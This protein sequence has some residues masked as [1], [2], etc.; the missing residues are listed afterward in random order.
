[1][2]VAV[3]SWNTRELLRGCLGSLELAASGGLADVWVVDNGSTDG[4]AAMVAAEF[5][6]VSLL[7]SEENSGFGPAV[8]DVAQRSSGEWVAPANADIRLSEGAL[9][10]LVQVGV[11][12]PSS[13]VIAP[14]LVLPNGQTQHSIYP[15]P[16]LPFTLLFNLGLPRFSRGLGRRWCLPGAWDPDRERYVPWAVGAFLL[17]RRSAWEEVG[18]FD[19]AQWMYAEDLDLGWRLHK[20]G[21]RTR[22]VPDA[23]VHHDESAATAQAWGDERAMRWHRSTY[24]WLFRRRGAA[25]A[26]ITA[27]I[28]VI[29]GYARATLLT[30]L[31]IAAP[32]RWRPARR[33]ALNTAR[34]HRVGFAPRS[35]LERQR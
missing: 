35:T 13:A 11:D 3:V 19:P 9:E 1:M 24:A 16:T 32:D 29:G 27:L 2:S 21:W 5:P 33:D 34:A 8:N 28:N 15:F 26:R 7:A 23:V 18:G 25:V 20:A 17:V 30:P 14:R 6:W 31:A 22:Y 12:D 10:R 4:S